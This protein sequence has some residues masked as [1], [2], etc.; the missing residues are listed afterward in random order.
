MRTGRV[1]WYYK[2]K[3]YGFI[4]PDDEERDIF[5]YFIDITGDGEKVLQPGEQV[6]FEVVEAPL[7]QRATNV[8]K[9]PQQ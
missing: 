3:G 9:L 1:I 2:E 8:E 6:K 7:G 5:V 4:R